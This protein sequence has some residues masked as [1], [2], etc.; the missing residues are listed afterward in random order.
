[1]I[2]DLFA[3]ARYALRGFGL[4]NQPGLRRYVAIPLAINI[5]LF[6][7]GV[8]FAFQQFGLLLD[9]L[10]GFLP[11]WLDW[12]TWLLWPLFGLVILIVVFYT[13]TLLANLVGAPF[14]ALLAAKIEER[15]TG[16]VPEGGNSL[17]ALAG[18]IGHS[19]ASELRKLLY[20][21]LWMIPLLL[22]LVIPGV[23]LFAPLAWAL[24]GAWML[25]IEY[26][27]Y[28]MGNHDYYFA[29][30]K[31][32]LAKHRPLALGFGGVL[33]VMTLVPVLNFLA[34]PVGVAGATAL[35]VERLAEAE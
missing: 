5:V 16:T 6:A 33:L 23:N 9:W 21:A 25:A 4:A 26:A 14:N 30:E 10:A 18:T 15:M 7:F 32:L 8:W 3:G 13:F 24:F 2:A 17:R 1:M 20:L 28:P 19:V 22:L 35:W 34:M 29:Q 12:L 31:A 11:A 27:D